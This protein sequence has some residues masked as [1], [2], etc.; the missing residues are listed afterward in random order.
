M[1]YA[2][3]QE[4]SFQRDFRKLPEQLRVRLST[5]IRNLQDDPFRP[6][7]KADIVQLA[8]G[9]HTKYRLRVGTYRIFYCVEG[10]TVKLLEVEHRKRAY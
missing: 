4:R 8:G 7:P 1:T 9:Q 3:L 10:K 5:A 6:R 2:I